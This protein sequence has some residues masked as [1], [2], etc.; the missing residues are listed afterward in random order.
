MNKCDYDAKILKYLRDSGNFEELEGEVLKLSMLEEMRIESKIKAGQKAG[1]FLSES[2]NENV[3]IPK[4]TRPGL[5]YGLP[6][7][8]KQG[9]PLRPIVSF[10][11]T[12]SYDLAK[13]LSKFIKPL[14]SNDNTVKDTFMFVEF[15]KEIK[16]TCDDVV[17]SFDI[18]NFYPSI[19]VLE[20][21][22]LIGDEVYEGI[23]KPNCSIEMFKDL[24][25]SVLVGNLVMFNNKIWKQVNGVAMGSLSAADVANAYMAIL[26]KRNNI[27]EKAKVYKRYVDDTFVICDNKESL[28][29]FFSFMNTISPALKLTKEDMTDNVLGFLDVKVHRVGSEFETSVYRKKTDTSLMMNYNSN[30]P[31]KYKRNLVKSL[32]LRY[33]RI[34]SNNERFSHD[35]NELKNRFLA[36]G[37]PSSFV[38]KYMDETRKKFERVSENEIGRELN[39]RK[40]LFLKMPF[41]NQASEWFAYT[42]KSYVN[43]KFQ[44][45]ELQPVLTV[46][47][48]IQDFVRV[49]REVPVG[50][51]SDVIYQYKCPVCSESYVGETHRQL[52]IRAYEH[53][54]TSWRTGKA[55]KTPGVSSVKEHMLETGH[56]GNMS[57]FSIIGSNRFGSTLT[58]RILEARFI[59]KIKPKINGNNCGFLL[60]LN[61]PAW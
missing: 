54:G 7:V 45:L 15:L 19:P 53:I 36:N 40:K 50:L 27:G 3:L 60:K 44:N 35:I 39:Q 46:T 30:I 32:T 20:A 26:E 10:V 21:I 22:D 42:L 12:A 51:R 61:F 49:R 9:L 56:K 8:H 47:N 6:K 43:E 1:L 52:Q 17:S 11:N 29:E 13:W 4:G 59:E 23:H 34:C 2:N 33:L 14:A 55:V 48:R 41:L 18:E 28:D 57:N 25:K 5:V 38:N 24:L 31:T 37:F 58:R 16:L